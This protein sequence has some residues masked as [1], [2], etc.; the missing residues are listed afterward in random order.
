MHHFVVAPA[1][2]EMNR[3]GIYNQGGV[4]TPKP[5]VRCILVNHGE[6]RVSEWNRPLIFANYSVFGLFTVIFMG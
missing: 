4:G 3:L 6:I 2:I 1:S 5:K